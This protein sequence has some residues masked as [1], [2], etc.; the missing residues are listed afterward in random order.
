MLSWL[1]VAHP[2]GKTLATVNAPALEL[3]RELTSV[4]TIPIPTSLSTPSVASSRGVAE[5]FA[6]KLERTSHHFI[7]SPQL[8]QKKCGVVLEGGVIVEEGYIISG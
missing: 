4:Y 8:R 1:C 5:A 2:S 3:L 6:P 7:S